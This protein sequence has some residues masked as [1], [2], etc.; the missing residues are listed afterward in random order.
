MK[1]IYKI[2]DAVTDEDVSIEFDS[3][4]DFEKYLKGEQP[5]LEP[6]TGTSKKYHASFQ[7]IT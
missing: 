2:K 1:N 6:I 3:Q 7:L 5:F 4:E